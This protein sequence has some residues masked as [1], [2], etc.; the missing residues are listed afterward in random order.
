MSSEYPAPAAAPPPEPAPPSQPSLRPSS[1]AGYEGLIAAA[2]AAIRRQLWAQGCLYGGAAG[3]VLLAAAGGLASRSPELARGLL[4]GS[5]IVAAALAGLFG[6]ILRWRR[7]GDEAR[8]ARSLSE[9]MPEISLDLLAAVELK[10]ALGKENGFSLQLAHAILKQV[11]QLAARQDVARAVDRRRTKL[12]VA[13]FSAA[14]LTTAAF[15]LTSFDTW[16][17]GFLSV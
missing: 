13:V 9:R 5:P 14:S 4:I 11:D 3:L 1:R 10:R 12:A 2:R 6:L 7:L 15:V 16:F 8:T 17:S